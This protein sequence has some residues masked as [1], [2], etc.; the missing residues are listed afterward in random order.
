MEGRASLAL[1]RQASSTCGGPRSV[2]TRTG[3]AGGH[4]VP[5]LQRGA[6]SSQSQASVILL[7]SSQF[8]LSSYH[9]LRIT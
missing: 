7:Q 5:Q 2:G 9:Q 3:L 8:A 6:S 4:Q 1:E